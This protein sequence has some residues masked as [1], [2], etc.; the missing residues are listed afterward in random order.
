MDASAVA[1]IGT[2]VGTIGG[3]GGSWLS[4]LGQ[5]RQHRQQARDERERWREEI[6]R[7]AYNTFIATAKQLSAAW[8]RA[9]DQLWEE[10]SGP[11]DWQARFLEAHAAWAQ[12]S[13]AA[14]AVSVAGPS[15]VADAAD[16]LRKA[17]SEWEM[18][19]TAWSHAAIRGGQGRLDDFDVRF[20]AAA[21]AKRAPDRAFQQAA[22]KALGTD[23]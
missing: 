8:W 7:E 1:V 6:R 20:K 15:D 23:T 5:S 3:L 21:E 17:M 13:T 10:G 11:D 12:F 22:R 2:A 9:A 16:D 18:V 4:M 14:A 19:G